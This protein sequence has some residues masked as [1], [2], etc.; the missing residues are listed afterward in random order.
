MGGVVG[1]LSVTLSNPCAHPTPPT[2]L[3]LTGGPGQNSRDL[4]VDGDERHVKDVRGG[5]DRQGRVLER[6]QVYGK[7]EVAKSGQVGESRD[8]DGRGE[9]GRDWRR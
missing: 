6:G 1:I 3:G 2:I 4:E 8:E 7:H 9:L 5:R